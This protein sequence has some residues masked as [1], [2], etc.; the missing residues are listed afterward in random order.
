M[1]NLRNIKFIL[2]KYFKWDIIILIWFIGW[3]CMENLEHDNDK[4]IFSYLNPINNDKLS[5]IS[6]KELDELL[7]YI[8][9][10]YL[11][12]RESLGFTSR[13]TFGIEI[14]I[15]HFIGW[16]DL[17]FYAFQ[18]KLDDVVGNR[19]WKAKNDRTL[20]E[21]REIASEVLIDESSSWE[22][23]KKV[24]AYAKTQGKIGINCSSHVHGGSQILGENPLY[25]H[26]LFRLWSVYENVIYRFCYGEYLTHRP[27]ITTYARPAA[28]FF[29]ER[30]A[31]LGDDFDYNLI[32]MLNTIEPRNM[33]D[34]YSKKFGISYWRMLADDDYQLYEDFNKINDGCTVEYRAPNP[35]LDEIVWQNYINFFIKFMLYCRSDKFD[36]EILN[37]RKSE[38]I[39]IFSN[40][41]EYS[42]I[43][44]D[45]AIELCDLIFDNNLDKIYFLRQ[46]I[47]SFEVADKPLV[48][49]RK[50]TVNKDRT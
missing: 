26:R 30:L 16:K 22:K 8:D 33:F 11:E 17:A 35:T 45:Q 36:E 13:D 34:R 43:Y 44:L 7:L 21:G 23:I 47:K 49:A 12:Y 37:R 24:C 10:Y 6:K 28:L 5:E 18:R 50:F 2:Y 19:E 25:W 20:C 40:I 3:V 31:L 4:T 42:K 48:R 15:E 9:K 46:Y 32:K 14:E 41:E 29:E 38:V 27:N 39:S 1:E